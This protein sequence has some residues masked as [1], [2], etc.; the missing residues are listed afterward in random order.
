MPG[1]I[2]FLGCL[3]VL[4]LSML[5]QFNLRFIS[6]LT[7]SFSFAVL[8]HENISKTIKRPPVVQNHSRLFYLNCSEVDL[9]NITNVLF[10]WILTVLGT[11]LILNSITN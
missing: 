8:A 3:F 9:N 6:F 2:Y 4:F 7:F 11:N 1:R 10:P 5:A